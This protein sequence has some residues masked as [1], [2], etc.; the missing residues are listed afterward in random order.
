[1]SITIQ[2]VGS[3]ASENFLRFG[4]IKNVD[5]IEIFWLNKTMCTPFMQHPVARR[6]AKNILDE[7]KKQLE[8][9]LL[10]GRQAG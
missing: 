1:M 5:K 7:I 10:V 2:S 8:S 6:R 9:S 3:K 4:D